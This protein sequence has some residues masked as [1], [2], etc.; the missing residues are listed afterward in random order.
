[1][2]FSVE[3]EEAFSALLQ[4]I[5]AWKPGRGKAMQL[6]ACWPQVGADFLRDEGMLVIGRA[7]NGYGTPFEAEEVRDEGKCRS[8]AA[9]CR[10]LGE[11]REPLGWVHDVPT[12]Y[13]KGGTIASRSAF[14]RV[15]RAFLAQVQGGEVPPGS[16][17]H[18]RLAWSNLMKVAPATGGNPS[19][20][21]CGC[22][23]DG[24]IRL[25]GVELKELQPR[26]VLVIAGRDW[27]SSFL[28]G[29]G[30]GESE[31]PVGRLVSRLATGT[32][33]WILTVRPEGKG[34]S[35]FASEIALAIQ[36]LN[37]SP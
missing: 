6:A 25:L 21:L 35:E 22:Q 5:G 18:R 3:Y 37:A 29:L 4:K 1:M 9:Q 27:Y 31:R 10:A 2:R 19:G 7:P 24:C 28:E 13:K 15:T 26:Y 33:K 8:L 36:E 16:D 30:V 11:G 32:Q 34:E 14:W 23:R 12:G 20:T 17:W